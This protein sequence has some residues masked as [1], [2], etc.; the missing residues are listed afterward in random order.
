MICS[1]SYSGG[2]ACAAVAMNAHKAGHAKRIKN[3][4][5][6]NPFRGESG[7]TI[8]K[9]VCLSLVSGGQGKSPSLS[10][11]GFLFSVPAASGVARGQAKLLREGSHANEGSAL[12]I[13]WNRE[14]T[15]S[16]MRPQALGRVGGDFSHR[17]ERRLLT[18]RADATAAVIYISADSFISPCGARANRRCVAGSSEKTRLS[19]RAGPSGGDQNRAFHAPS[20]PILRPFRRISINHRD[21]R[22]CLR[23]EVLALFVHR[24]GL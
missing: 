5:G 1:H 15:R 2:S 21:R 23:A 20:T 18:L 22:F 16:S 4:S 19:R 11:Y 10:N 14:G 7:V 9:T 12:R 17:N 8:S 24:G 13:V 6:M 3:R